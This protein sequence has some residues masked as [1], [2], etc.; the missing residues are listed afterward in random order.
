MHGLIARIEMT[1]L[2]LDTRMVFFRE[3]G[4]KVGYPTAARKFLVAALQINMTAY[5]VF[6]GSFI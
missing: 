5:F 1:Y 4:A 6:I 2:T 3:G